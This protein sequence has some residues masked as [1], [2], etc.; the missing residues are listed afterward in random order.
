[1]TAVS[2]PAREAATTPSPRA[3]VLL[4][5]VA[6][7]LWGA[8]FVMAR[9]ALATI[10]PVTLIAGRF[11]VA[12]TLLAVIALARRRPAGRATIVAGLLS[13]PFNAAGYALQASGLTNTSAGSSAFLT[14][15]GTLMV[16]PFA[17][18][19]LRQRPGRVVWAGIALALLG[20]ALLSWRT[21]FRFGR[22]ELVT[23]LGATSYAVSLVIVA[24]HIE[25]AE[26]VALTA[27]QT[28]AGAALLLPF[29]APPPAGV[30]PV[31]L[32]RFAYLALAGSLVAPLL[33]VTAQR[34][35]PPARIGILFALEPVFAVV[36]AVL[37]GAE[38]FALR[39]WAGALL[40]LTAVALVEWRPWSSQPTP[41]PATT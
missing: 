32:A 40:I 10:P 25:R 8:T 30:A 36:F 6:T 34:A 27:V 9:D 20:S 22:G 2:G 5:V 23:L 29:A 39:W 1:V 17:W 7:M 11:A 21:G 37:F 33:Q 14:A 31:T 15:A 18:L 19:L 35:L 16:A 12:G 24:A 41:R 38:R 13:A 26:P 4:M 3:G 28:L